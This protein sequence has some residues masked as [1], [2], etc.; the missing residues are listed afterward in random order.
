MKLPIAINLSDLENKDIDYEKSI[1]K[2]RGMAFDVGIPAPDDLI[3]DGN[4]HRFQIGGKKTNKNGWYILNENEY[5]IIG[6]IGDHSRTFG[7]GKNYIPITAYSRPLSPT[8]QIKVTEKIKKDSE[9]AKIEMKQ[10]HDL[11]AREAAFIWSK[12]EYASTDHP[13]LKDK[14]LN[15]TH[16]SKISGDGCLVLPAVDKSGEIKCVQYIDMLGNKRT[17]TGGS[18]K[19]LFWIIGDIKEKVFICEGFATGATVK[20][21]TELPVV[22]A[23]NAS[24]LTS[25][26]KSIKELYPDTEIIIAADN[27]CNNKENT[28]R[29]EAERALKFAGVSYIMPPNH[30]DF[31]DYKAIGVN[32]KDILCPQFEE[33]WLISGIDLSVQPKP[34]KWL[35]KGWLQQNSTMMI[36]GPSGVGKTFVVLDMALHIALGKEKWNGLKVHN[37]PVVYL[38]GEGHRGIAARYNGWIQYNNIDKSFGDQFMVSRSGTELDQTH[39]LKKVIDSITNSGV[40]P[41]LIVVDTLH[42]FLQEDEDKDMSVKGM[43]RSCAALKEKFGCSVLIVHHTGHSVMAQNRGKGSVSWRGIMEVEMGLQPTNKLKDPE[44]T[45]KMEK[46][47]DG[48]YPGDIYLKRK[49][50]NVTDWFDEDDEQ[51]TTVIIKSAE[52]PEPREA[53]GLTKAKTNISEAWKA[54]S[55]ELSLAGDPYISTKNWK[56]Y[57]LIDL[58]RTEDAATQAV[59]KSGG[60]VVGKLF[61]NNVIAPHK[62]GYIVIDS[63]L[64]TQMLLGTNGTNSTN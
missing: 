23:F 34:I 50:V 37:G 41:S 6:A 22:I 64:V 5:G 35:L 53:P 2:V 16:G 62:D 30:G 47:K 7:S 55:S 61:K 32:I 39:G 31:N 46:M 52:T 43:D 56:K 17:Q 28:G 15:S 3:I 4:V 38:A 12:T 36:H 57:F 10:K 42:R 1:D 63:V 48:E 45:L 20:E 9:K 8:E 40:N 27:D 24:N 11:A 13:Y 29:I 54:Y 60:G 21:E 44:M 49:Q 51:V 25:T 18:L 19:D 33:D 58:G 14:G 26:A 59:K